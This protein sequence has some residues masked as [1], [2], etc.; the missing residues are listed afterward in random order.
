M[1][2]N[3]SFL[4]FQ[5]VLLFPFKNFFF[6]LDI[7]LG[8]L[9]SCIRVRQVQR[10]STN[11]LSTHDLDEKQNLT[12]HVEEMRKCC[13]TTSL[14]A[15]QKLLKKE[16]WRQI[17]SPNNNVSVTIRNKSCSN[18]INMNINFH[19]L[20][21]YQRLCLFDAWEKKSHQ[22]DF[23]ARVSNG[24]NACQCNTLQCSHFMHR[25]TYM[26]GNKRFEY[27]TSYI[28]GSHIEKVVYL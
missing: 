15:F 6:H 28:R 24:H 1:Q 8:V 19:W 9:L 10:A 17:Q 23:W 26:C 7:C 14:L 22:C 12:F 16:K 4:F 5:T 13:W 2:R 3:V 11:T 18:K 21:F 25:K 20:M 27:I